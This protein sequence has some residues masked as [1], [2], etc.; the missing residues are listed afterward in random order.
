MTDH[1]NEEEIL[2]AMLEALDKPDEPEQQSNLPAE[3]QASVMMEAN[4]DYISPTLSDLEQTRRPQPRTACDQCPNAVWFSTKEEVRCYCRVM[5]L[6]SWDSKKPSE[7]TAC[8]GMYLG[9]D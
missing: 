3:Q 5:F 7:I 8:D 6:V 1:N 9:Q 2:A 4:Q